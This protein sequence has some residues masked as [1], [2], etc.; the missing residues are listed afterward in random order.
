MSEEFAFLFVVSK[1]TF[2]KQLY[3][4]EYFLLTIDHVAVYVNGVTRSVIS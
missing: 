1:F 2:L 4:N 3:I